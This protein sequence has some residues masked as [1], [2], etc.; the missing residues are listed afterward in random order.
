MKRIGNIFGASV[1]KVIQ[2]VALSPSEKVQDQVLREKFLPASSI[3]ESQSEL[4][5]EQLEEFKKKTKTDGS[6]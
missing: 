4:F 3:S 5:K 1:A 2:G 6:R